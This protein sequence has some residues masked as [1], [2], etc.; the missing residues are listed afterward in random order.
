MK[1]KVFSLFISLILILMACTGCSID[2]TE[3]GNTTIPYKDSPSTAYEQG[4]IL[5]IGSKVK[6]KEEIALVDVSDTA[7]I[8][9]ALNTEEDIV[10]A[11]M[12]KKDNTYFYNGKETD[13][14]MPDIDTTCIE[15]TLWDDYTMVDKAVLKIHLFKG[16]EYKGKGATGTETIKIDNTD[17]ILVWSY[18]K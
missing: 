11:P 17:Y 14:Y 5:D 13:F 7:V 6:I 9:V 16:S 12:S 2:D 4:K 1:V 15:S 10:L 18:E 8:W 3:Q